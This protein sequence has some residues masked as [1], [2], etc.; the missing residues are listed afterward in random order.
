MGGRRYTRKRKYRS[1]M[2]FLFK[3][4]EMLFL[5]MFL[6]II[7]LPLLAAG[8]S[9]PLWTGNIATGFDGGRGTEDDPYL[10]SNGEQLAYFSR[11][12]NTGV[13]YEG[14]YIELT[15]DILLNEMNSDGTFVSSS[16]KQFTPIGNISN[17][18]LGHFNGADYEI[19]GLYINISYQDYKGL[20]GNAGTGSVIRNLKVSGSI[21]GGNWTGAVAGYTN[22][23]IIE[24]SVNCPVA[25]VTW[26]DHHGGIAGEAGEDSIISNCIVL[27]SVEGGSF[28][29][30]VA[31]TS[32]GQITECVAEGTVF[33]QEYAGGMAGYAQGVDSVIKNCSFSGT[34]TGGNIQCLGGI[35][36]KSEGLIEGCSI[37]S[38][39]SGENSYV[40]G[41][42]G[43]AAGEGSKIRNCTIS[44]NVSTTGGKVYTGGVAG[45]SDGEIS[46]CIID[47]EVTAPN[48]YIGGVAGYACGANNIISNCT[49]SGIITATAGE[50]FVGGVAGYT[51]GKIAG[52]ISGCAVTGQHH[53]I[54][55]IVGYAGTGS[56]VRNSASSGAIA[57]NSEI[58]GI[59]G[60]TDGI[61]NICIN[62][63][64][65]NGNNG[66]TG[67]IAGSAGNNSVVGNSFNSGAINGST[68]GGGQGGIGGI[69]GYV[70]ENT[71][72]HHNLNMG[73]VYGN[74]I[75]GSIIG[76]SV[77][78]DN[79]WNNYYYDY[80][81]APG[82]ANN[83]D[84]EGA[85]PIGDMTWEEIQELLN[86]DNDD[87]DVWDQDWDD[88]GVTKPDLGLETEHGVF[89]SVIKEG[90]YYSSAMLG[91][92]T[93]VT[94]TSESIF[95]VLFSFR[96]EESFEP[97]QHIL[98]LKNN[99]EPVEFP[100]ATSITMLYEE[101]YYY[102]N[103]AEAED[104]IML[105]SF[106]KMGSTSDYFDPPAAE[107][108]DVKDYLFIIDFTRT[109]ET[110][111]IPAGS[112]NIKL[113]AS[114]KN[115]S[116]TLPKVIVTGKNN[117]DLSVSG[118]INMFAINLSNAPVLGYDY[119]TAGGI[120]A[121]EFSLE[122]ETENGTE[123]VPLP[124]GTKI[125]RFSVSSDLPYAFVPVTL[126]QS[127]TVSLDVS[128]SVTPF[129]YGD[130]TLNVTIYACTDALNPRGGFVLAKGA[131]EIT[132]AEPAVYAIKAN[133]ENRVFDQSTSSIPVVFNIQTLGSG[134]VKSTLQRKYGST[135]INVPGQ[136]DLPVAIVGGKATLYLPASSPKS[137]YR[138]VLSLY[139]ENGT[140]K[141][142]D[143][144]ENII[145]K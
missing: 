15:R 20:F 132:F 118:G 129:D 142:A 13:T 109:L 71:V 47:I 93:T 9:S 81:D 37:S 57:G 124:A 122:K 46:G 60:Y 24:C 134:T 5:G 97:D 50:G 95:S 22:G 106:I 136:V 64:D 23:S 123:I 90:K 101:S 4:L 36:G 86:Q 30:G 133:A 53:Y 58:G 141:K 107:E 102:I 88:G 45:R 67:G 105:G 145:V 31:G 110:D 79:V 117:Y 28:V 62:T 138:F 29:G 119:K 139:D 98:S 121:C 27:S 94:V 48:S 34:V 75:V 42:V 52:C 26:K 70:S 55:G 111:Q 73:T 140:V 65:V 112:Y 66:R 68:G 10:I 56:E 3:L 61:I 103:L 115:Y 84:I 32:K 40:G 49:V 116:G 16:P 44:G 51:D 77:S 114:N 80:E 130:Y 63:G 7:F 78:E 108:K 143:A 2:R 41:V 43:Y 33:G 1:K 126:N 54:G 92:Q 128:K 14:M 113:A 104:S 85:A 137:T 87:G 91:D 89:N 12:V 21:A 38:T 131:A 59:A 6:V 120:Y 96:Y 39:I 99:N 17:K 72:V 25:T 69:V 74:Q 19:I 100:A 135:Y 18:F 83:N 8:G 125:N 76:N 82:G 35:A 11:Q 127:E 144:V